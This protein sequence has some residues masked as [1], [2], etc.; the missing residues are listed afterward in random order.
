MSS[1]GPNGRLSRLRGQMP[2]SASPIADA[3]RVRFSAAAGTALR[4]HPAQL[5]PVGLSDQHRVAAR[6]K[7]TDEGR[8]PKSANSRGVTAHAPGGRRRAHLSIATSRRQ[9]RTFPKHLHPENQHPDPPPDAPNAPCLQPPLESPARHRPEGSRGPAR[10]WR[11]R[12]EAWDNDGDERARDRHIPNGQPF[13]RRQFRCQ[14]LAVVS[15]FHTDILPVPD[16][17]RPRT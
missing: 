10:V 12:A 2:E 7:R 13:E 14:C 17:L 3:T 5:A 11:W 8:P 9:A 1:A 16:R 4:L 6:A 15:P